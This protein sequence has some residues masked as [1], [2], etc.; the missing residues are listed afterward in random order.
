[1]VV[2]AAAVTNK[3]GKILVSRQ[4]MEMKRIRIEGLLAGFSK[5]VGKGKNQHTLIETDEVRYVYQPLEGLYVLIITNPQSNI[6]EDLDTLRLLSKLIP[7]Y[8]EGTTEEDVTEHNFDLIF[9]FDEVVTNG[10]KEYVTLQQVKTYT[11]MDSHEERIQNIITHSKINEAKDQAREKA[12]AIEMK[13]RER[14]MAGVGM[15]GDTSGMGGMGSDSVEQHTMHTGPSSR[16]N[17]PDFTR[18]TSPEPEKDLRTGPSANAGGMVLGAPDGHADQFV[19][20][21]GIKDS[22]PV[23]NPFE[24]KKTTPV[25]EELKDGVM[26]LVDVS[27]GLSVEMGSDGSVKRME[28]KGGVKVTCFSPD[29]SRVMLLT[30]GPLKKPFMTRMQ[31]R[32]DKKKWTKGA[33]GSKDP[34]KPFPTGS[35][36]ALTLVTW[37]LS[38]TN[39]E[40]VPF[41]VNCWPASEGNSSVVS[42]E[43]ERQNPAIVCKHVT[44]SI[45]CPSSKAP[46]IVSVD[47]KAEFLSR[48]KV[49]TWQIDEISDENESGTLEFS[50]PKM[51]SASF[52]PVDVTFSSPTLYS[53]MTVKKVVQ[54]A[55]GKEVE[56]K[57]K[58]MLT[59]SK[60]TIS[61]EGLED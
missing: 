25:A 33:L 28:V 54:A 46:E 52:F 30:N 43:F 5:L 12:K 4:F 56:H 37:K 35:A 3:T 13:R 44:I 59:T 21:L 10:F 14:K 27:E 1:M 20:M 34:T 2:L 60:Y 23:H 7:Q 41:T 31:P 29:V 38:T 24:V 22:A 8:C 39:E 61:A 32:L 9:A 51:D 42:V 58:S 36:D 50:V 48:D 40:M 47:G 45:P 57:L 18:E 53:K 15:G 16:S 17:V 6:M 49:L 55:D 26:L 11:T 19:K